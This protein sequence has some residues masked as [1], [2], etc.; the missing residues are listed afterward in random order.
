[1][2]RCRFPRRENLIRATSSA[3]LKNGLERT[4]QCQVEF[5]VDRASANGTVVDV[6]LACEMVGLFR[7]KRECLRIR[8]AG[9]L[10]QFAV[11][12][13]CVTKMR[14]VAEIDHGPIV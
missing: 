14:C 5:R 9:I 6:Q 10:N 3:G 12:P 13:E 7:R 8:T 2:D 4:C 1:M 11:K